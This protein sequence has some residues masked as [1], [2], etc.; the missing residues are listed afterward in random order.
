MKK[1]VALILAVLLSLT[2]VSAFAEETGK[3]LIVEDSEARG[4]MLAILRETGI[5]CSRVLV[6]CK[7]GNLGAIAL[8]LDAGC[9]ISL[10]A[11]L[12]DDADALRTLVGAI[13]KQ[14]LLLESSAC[15]GALEIL[16]GYPARPD[17]IAFA[18]EA[19][20]DLC[21]TDQ[22]FRNALDFYGL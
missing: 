7:S 6:R 22:L 16:E 11:L 21:P 20:K 12:A 18:I 1:F 13:P 10:S 9:Y 5:D 19:I 14:R 2:A 8:W 15:D 17:Q 3:R 4:E